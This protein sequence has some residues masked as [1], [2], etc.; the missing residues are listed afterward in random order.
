MVEIGMH[1]IVNVMMVVVKLLY[2][3]DVLDRHTVTIRLPHNIIKHFTLMRRET[4]HDPHM[5]LY[6]QA[7]HTINTV[8]QI[9]ADIHTVKYGHGA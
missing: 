8:T 3:Y 7:S 4:T 5:A 9:H 6:K 2:K 1:R